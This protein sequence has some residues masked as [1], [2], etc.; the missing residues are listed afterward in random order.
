L[1]VKKGSDFGAEFHFSMPIL[2][3]GDYSI[4][5][6]IAE[7]TQE[8]HIQHSWIHDAII[9]RIHSTKPCFGLFGVAMTDVSLKIF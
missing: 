8:N 4:S 5:P 1:D 3:N 2:P 7:G 9:F 6:A